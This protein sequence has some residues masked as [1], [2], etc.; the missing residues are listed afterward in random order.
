MTIAYKFFP[1]SYRLE[2]IFYFCENLKS[3]EKAPDIPQHS[4]L[5]AIV[6]LQQDN[7]LRSFIED[8]NDEYGYWDRIKY[9][10]NSFHKSPD[11][12]WA[13]IKAQR[14]I[15]NVSVKNWGKYNIHFA[16]TD[17]MQRQCHSFDMNFG[18]RWEYDFK[19]DGRSFYNTQ[20]SQGNAAQENVP[21]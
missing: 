9:I 11:E 5:Q 6:E 14:F 7:E 8:L 13:L 4:L 17:R 12:L 3:M 15:S 20:D 1:L 2:R 10:R 18:G 16:L 19:Y 21:R